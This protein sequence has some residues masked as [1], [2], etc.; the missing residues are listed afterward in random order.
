VF[1][2]H[3]FHENVKSKGCLDGAMLDSVATMRCKDACALWWLLWIAHPS[4]SR[5]MDA[6]AFAS[7]KQALSW[8]AK[9]II[10][11][12]NRDKAQDIFCVVNV[13]G[14][15]MLTKSRR[16]ALFLSMAFGAARLASCRPLMKLRRLSCDSLVKKAF[17]D[18]C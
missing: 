18:R 5:T 6:R 2:G 7:G 11:G 15:V 1:W 13:S 14:L 9:T 4:A 3:L 17:D 16:F 8:I 10:Q 12:H